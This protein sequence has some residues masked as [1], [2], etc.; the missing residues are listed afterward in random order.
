MIDK[1]IQKICP[2]CKV[3]LEYIGLKQFHEGTRWGVLGDLAELV[4]S[5]EQL[6]MYKCP[7]C[8]K[9]EFY[10][11]KSDQLPELKAEKKSLKE[12]LGF[13]LMILIAVVIIALIAVT[14]GSWL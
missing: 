10:Q 12:A 14:I 6:K 8:K 7:N 13:T 2:I 11:E 4:V 9:I 3:P 1:K 5:R